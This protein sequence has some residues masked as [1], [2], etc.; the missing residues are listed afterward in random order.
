MEFKNRI[1]QIGS[2]SMGTR[3]MRDLYSRADVTLALFETRA[4]WRE[5]A[6]QRFAIE[7]F[8][9]IEEALDWQPD[10]IVISTPP[11]LN[12]PFVKLALEY[13]KNFF[14]EADIWP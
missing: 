8:S 5:T 11:D 7:C 6:R 10:S 13:G 4:D 12:G 1:L 14:S 3:R 9:T 2:G